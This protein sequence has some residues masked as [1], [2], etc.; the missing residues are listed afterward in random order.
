MKSSADNTHNPS[1]NKAG[2]RVVFAG[3]PDFAA[4]HLDALLQ[5]QRSADN[6]CKIEL[7]AVYTQPDRPAG[8]GKKL[9]PSPVKQLAIEHKLPVCQPE[10]LKT[11][12]EQALLAEFSPDVMVVVA[13]GQILPK[14]VLDIPRLGCINVHASLLPRWRGAAPIQ[15]ALEAGDQQ[16]GVTI[17]QMDEGLDTGDMLAKRACDIVDTDTAAS[18]HEKLASIG[19]EALI[20]VLNQLSANTVQ[21]VAQDDA[22]STYAAKI[23]KQEAMI[24]WRLS[25]NDLARKIRAFNPFPI[26]FSL[27][28][29][30]RVRIW[31]ANVVKSPLSA[32]P[33]TIASSADGGI[34]VAC[35]TDALQLTE[36]QL[37]GRNP[38][39]AAEILKSRGQLFHPG[40]AF[41]CRAP[42]QQ[43]E[44]DS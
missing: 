34:V 8:R 1:K 24:D 16:T 35:G 4:H 21:P 17:M 18:L 31:Q 44:G 36:L 9:T 7:A 2:L 12:D 27:I 15:R 37:P 43:Q 41:E 14:A 5:A 40:N 11:A 39:P 3:T 28:S 19:T 33:G 29:G 32:S 26:A 6:R 25:A 42:A 38:L 13:Y 22:L 30:E 10:T 20:D 23:A